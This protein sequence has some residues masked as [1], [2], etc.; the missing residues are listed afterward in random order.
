MSYFLRNFLDTCGISTD[1]PLFQGLCTV[2]IK[3][4]A[5][6]DPA[7][8]VAKALMSAMQVACPISSLCMH[9]LDFSLPPN[10]LLAA[11]NASLVSY[12]FDCENVQCSWCFASTAHLQL[13]TSAHGTKDDERATSDRNQFHLDFVL[14]DC[15]P[16]PCDGLAIVADIDLENHTVHMVCPDMSGWEL[17]ESEVRSCVRCANNMNSATIST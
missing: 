17:W 11:F 4:G 16:F 13:P 10:L 5:I 8:N 3:S 15:A 14:N 7:G 2:S 6:V 1:D 9:A 12:S